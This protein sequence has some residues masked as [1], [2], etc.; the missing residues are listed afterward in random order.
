MREQERSQLHAEHAGITAA[1]ADAY[2]NVAEE[3]MSDADRRALHE[4]AEPPPHQ[5]HTP[6]PGAAR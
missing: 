5:P 1:T 4:G 3:G 6:P 2:V